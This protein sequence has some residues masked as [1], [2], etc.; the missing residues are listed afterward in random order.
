MVFKPIIDFF[1]FMGK[2]IDA[3]GF[4]VITAYVR[5]TNY[6]ES[7]WTRN[8]VVTVWVPLTYSRNWRAA[9]CDVLSLGLKNS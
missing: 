6:S 9:G 4:P 5:Y 3:S 7:N 8:P 1:H 2:V